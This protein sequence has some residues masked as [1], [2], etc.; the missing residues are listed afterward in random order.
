MVLYEA[1]LG[2]GKHGAFATRVIFA[3]GNMFAN[4]DVSD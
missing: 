3:A 1:V 4:Y 2:E